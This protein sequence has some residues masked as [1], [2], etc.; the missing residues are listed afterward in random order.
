MSSQDHPR[1]RHRRLGRGEKERGQGA[2]RAQ[3][4][5]PVLT[6]PRELVVSRVAGPGAK[7][8]SKV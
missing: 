7:Q 5:D 1:L 4:Q 3:Q 8:D 2:I 6:R